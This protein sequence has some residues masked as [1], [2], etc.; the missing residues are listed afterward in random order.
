MTK[1]A[2][3]ARDHD[4]APD[5]R[6]TLVNPDG[7]PEGAA[8]ALPRTAKV[9]PNSPWRYKWHPLRWDWSE[10]YGW[11]PSLG[12]FHMANGLDGLKV[13]RKG[14][15]DLEVAVQ[16][17][18][19]RGWTVIDLGDRR[20]G[21]FGQYLQ[22]FPVRRGGV[23]HASIFVTPEIIGN[24]IE[25]VTDTALYGKFLE[26]LVSS[27]VVEPMRPV[28]RRLKIRKQGQVVSR[29]ENDLYNH[30][31]HPMVKIRYEREAR[32]LAGMNGEDVAAAVAEAK[33]FAKAVSS[34]AA[35]G[36]SKA[37]AKDDGIESLPEET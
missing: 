8:S 1:L 4:D 34:G 9:R 20:L 17:N 11:H 19:G 16:K 13:T 12:R 15:E 31:D 28:V 23:F 21:N 3:L 26:K 24:E 6:G 29:L 10:E 35:K 5:V 32:R 14:Y 37:K 33:E 25:W 7:T 27:G 22:T 18:K 2:Q 36:G 30:P